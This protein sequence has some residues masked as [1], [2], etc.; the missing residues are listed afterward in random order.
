MHRIAN[1]KVFLLTLFLI[2]GQLF[3]SQDI[4]AAGH[5]EKTLPGQVVM[6]IID[7]I[8]W[9]D[10]ENTKLPVIK[11]LALSGACGLMTTNPASGNPRISENTYPMIGSGTKIIGGSVGGLGLNV[12]ENYENGIAGNSFNRRTGNKIQSEQIV[13]LGIAGMAKAN[14]FLKSDYSPGLLGT[15]LHL[16]G[17]KT[18]VLGN[19]D[20][21]GQK[22][23]DERYK[24]FAVSIAMDQK[25]LVDYGNVSPDT[26]RYNHDRLAGVITSYD[27]IIRGFQTIKGKA[28]FIVVETG[29]ISRTEASRSVAKNDVLQKERIKVLT[30]IDRFLGLLTQTMNLRKDLLMI[31]V[32]GPAYNSMQNGN[33]LTPFIV[34]GKGVEKG[35]VWSGT[36]KRRG[37]ISNSDIAR[38]ILSFFEVSP[39]VK[40]DGVNKK[41]ILTGQT[42]QSRYSTNPFK[43]IY[44]LNQK[45]VFLHNSRYP[46]VKIYINSALGI[47]M[48]AFGAMLLNKKMGRYLKPLLLASTFIPLI[49]LGAPLIT[50]KTIIGAGVVV[51]VL[52]ISLTVLFSAIGRKL[53]I[54]PFLFST[55]L[56]SM[57]LI[58]DIFAGAP[59]NKTSPF[60]YD[61]MTGTRFYGIGNEYM[62]VLIG[63]SIVFTGLFCDRFKTSPALMKSVALACM[64]VTTYVIAAPGF[65]ANVGGAFAAVTG[66]CA[67]GL[68][69]FGKKVNIKSLL[70]FS[71]AITVLLVVLILFDVSRSVET[72]TH[73]GRTANQ[74]GINGFSEALIIIK[75]KAATNLRLIKYTSWS[76]FYVTSLA[77]IIFGKEKFCRESEVFNRNNPWFSKLLTAVLWASLFALIFNDSGIV[78]GATMINYAVMPYVY[79]LI[80]AREGMSQNER[81]FG[82]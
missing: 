56:S 58:I 68:L 10:L 15:I 22:L 38:Q 5:S 2:F 66:S 78:A 73:L 76:W 49:L 9:Q 19:A 60:S 21:P 3:F 8:S 45:L 75:R 77:I 13:Q 17:L 50:N 70:P 72:Q 79:G 63:S 28:D 61:A 52:T 41:I 81:L 46:F 24:R 71:L 47:I 74:I 1:L 14:R 31:V 69:L 12:W 6:V 54:N 39:T 55:G 43:E 57:I 64:A 30:E 25:G 37:L 67:V 18:G 35:V 34:V 82:D 51:L 59:L 20:L 33:Y 27:D 16:N 48:V 36:T 26:Y 40:V 7:K 42:I 29:D 65:G 4:F 32:P 23:P 62:G 44:A 53:S 11:R 80:V